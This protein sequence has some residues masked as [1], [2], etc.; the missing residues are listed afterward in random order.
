MASN[1]SSELPALAHLQA[2]RSTTDT[3]IARFQAG[4]DLHAD[5]SRLMISTFESGELTQEKL[6]TLTSQKDEICKLLFD[7]FSDVRKA[8]R[9]LSGM[10]F[11][12][13]SKSERAT[14]RDQKLLRETLARKLMLWDFLEGLQVIHPGGGLAEIDGERQKWRSGMVQNPVTEAKESMEAMKKTAMKKADR[15]MDTG[16]EF[17]PYKDEPEGETNEGD[18]LV[19][20]DFQEYDPKL[21]GHSPFTATKGEKV[22]LDEEENL[23]DLE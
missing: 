18:T 13:I 5:M 22:R 3:E 19:C 17:V 10:L 1:N 8:V 16:H 9:V 7:R 11:A 21:D 20:W 14:D 15:Q 2:L 4:L 12:F 6:A 23:I